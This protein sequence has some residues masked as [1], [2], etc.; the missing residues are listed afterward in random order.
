M[1]PPV[2]IGLGL[3]RRRL[4]GGFDPASLNPLEW[5]KAD[6]GTFQDSAL[7]TPATADAAPVG[8]WVAR[9][10]INALQATAAKRPT[11]R[12]NVQ[13]GLP[14][15]RWDGVDDFLGFTGLVQASGGRTA[16]CALNPT[17]PGGTS[18]HYVFDSATG[19]LILAGMT[20]VTLQT[21]WF[22]GAWKKPTTPATVDG[23]QILTWDLQVGTGEMLR[24]GTSLGTAAYTSVA[25]GA[26]SG[27]GASN[28]G[29]GSFIGMDMGEFLIYPAL[30]AAQRNQVIAYLRGRWGV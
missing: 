1:P 15:I 8:G 2:S 9:N 23:F 20:D 14:V 27:L 17:N 18:L 3:P 19:R 22:D 13:N 5:L 26:A 12:T 24:N 30:T 25:L 21:G 28:D 10:G 11:L 29:L 7:T 4:G 16:F 6:V